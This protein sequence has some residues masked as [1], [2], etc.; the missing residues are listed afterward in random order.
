VSGRYADVRTVGRGGQVTPEAY[1]DLV[2][3]VA[4]LVGEG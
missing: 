1:G 3:S 2:L 4:D